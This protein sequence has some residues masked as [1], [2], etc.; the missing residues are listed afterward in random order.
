[1]IS[2]TGEPGFLPPGM[3]CFNKTTLSGCSTT[4]LS[5][6]HV[7]NGVCGVCCQRVSNAGGVL[8][9][10]REYHCASNILSLCMIEFIV[11]NTSLRTK[12]KIRLNE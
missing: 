7:G 10:D 3:C 6:M 12:S 4:S 8:P 5:Q 1:M 2:V 11:A 9:V